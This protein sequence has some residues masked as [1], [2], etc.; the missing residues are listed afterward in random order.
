ME[1]IGCFRDKLAGQEQHATLLFCEMFG[2]RT[3]NSRQLQTGDSG[4]SNLGNHVQVDYAAFLNE[5]CY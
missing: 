1:L 2:L 4:R 3:E 5:S